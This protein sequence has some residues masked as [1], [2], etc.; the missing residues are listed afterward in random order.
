MDIAFTI[1]KVLNVIYCCKDHLHRG[2]H[3]NNEYTHVKENMFSI[4]ISFILLKYKLLVLLK[5]S[6]SVGSGDISYY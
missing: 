6:S 2:L 3:V 5:G 1:Q 4:S